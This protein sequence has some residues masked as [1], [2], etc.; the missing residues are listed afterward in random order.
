MQK[1]S[2]IHVWGSAGRD[3]DCSSSGVSPV[4]VQ[5]QYPSKGQYHTLP[6][7]DVPYLS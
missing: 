6:D 2:Q 3:L 5:E 4:L 7:Y 1:Q